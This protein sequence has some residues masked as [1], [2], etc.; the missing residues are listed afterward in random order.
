MEERQ[1]ALTVL[2]ALALLVV[3]ITG[4]HFHVHQ[5]TAWQE[6]STVVHAEHADAQT[7]C[8]DD[9]CG[10][11]LSLTEFWKN[12]NQGWQFFALLTLAFVLLLPATSRGSGNFPAV[13]AAPFDPPV[14]LRP[15]LRA[16]P[17]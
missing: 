11:D 17:L 14:F 8:Q 5:P 16:P 1:A 7:A 3:Q 4:L 10:V 2:L 12:P 13:A 6:P 15:P 9:V